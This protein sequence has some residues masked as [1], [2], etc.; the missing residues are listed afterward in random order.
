[1]PTYIST[2]RPAKTTFSLFK[3]LLL[4]PLPIPLLNPG[5]SFLAA[6]PDRAPAPP[7]T[8]VSFPPS[9]S[10]IPPPIS[11]I[12]TVSVSVI[13][14]TPIIISI[15]PPRTHTPTPTPTNPVSPISSKQLSPQIPPN[16]LHMHKITITTTIAVI[17]LVLSAGSF[18]KISDWREI[19]DNR[20]ARVK[21]SLKRLQ[22]GGSLV[23]LLELNINVTD[24]V[25][26]EVITNIKVL[27]LT[28]FA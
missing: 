1:M 17:L 15:P 3:S 19:G 9:V 12:I 6:F 24:H 26:G 28:K 27:D 13:P 16:Q 20:T 21:S 25:I 4:L 8:P 22:S 14:L 5:P 10:V 2:P 23:L 18:T 11:T 7:R